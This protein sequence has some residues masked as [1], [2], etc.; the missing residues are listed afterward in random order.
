LGNLIAWINRDF[1]VGPDDRVLFLAA[2]GFDLSVYD[3]FGLLAAGGS[4]R[5]VAQ[6]ERARPERLLALLLAE[7]ITFWDSGPPPPCS[8]SPRSSPRCR[9]PARAPSAGSS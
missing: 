3:V 5:V 9:R 4:V 2:M 7:P 6:S 8:S 1:G